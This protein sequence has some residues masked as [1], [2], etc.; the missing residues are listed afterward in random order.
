MKRI[1]LILMIAFFALNAE[2]SVAQTKE[3][4]FYVEKWSY[5]S[6]YFKNRGKWEVTQFSGDVLRRLIPQAANDSQSVISRISNI[7]QITLDEGNKAQFKRAETLFITEPKYDLI[8]SITLSGTTYKIFKAQLKRQNEYAILINNDKNYCICDI[9]GYLNDDQI[10][11]FIGVKN[12][13]QKITDNKQDSV[14]IIK[15]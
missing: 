10:L 2:N 1:F 9:V 12:D 3:L 5:N 6:D 14:E 13:G 11:S 8:L 15:P 4:K 7:F